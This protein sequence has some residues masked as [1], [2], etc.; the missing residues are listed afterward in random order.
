[1]APP[2]PITKRPATRRSK[3]LT[4][5][6]RARDFVDQAAKYFAEV[7]FDGGTRELARR[8]G[9]TQPLLYR[10][11]PSKDDLIREV[12]R[13]VF[14]DRWRPDWED[15]LADRSIPLRTRL[16]QFYNEYTDRIFTREWIRIY[17][18][19]GLRGVEINKWYNELVENK[20]LRRIC[21]ELRHDNGL[22]GVAD[23][24]TTPEME[25]AWSLHGGIIYF[26]IRKH[27]YGA[28][29]AED[30]HGVIANALDG[31]FGQAP[32]VFDALAR[33]A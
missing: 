17:L 10:Y 29:V 11:F 33:Q 2:E 13:T 15:L 8:L 18:F 26:G 22:A 23:D 25:L 5:E 24:V 7:G 31:F 4:P 12:Y 6:Q 20:V 14:L 30:K 19:S 21:A 16:E 9:V 32:N 27:I 1:M 3:R 28:D